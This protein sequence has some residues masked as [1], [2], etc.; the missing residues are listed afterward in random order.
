MPK[1][2]VRLE[3]SCRILS[4]RQSSAIGLF[5]QAK[6]DGG[7]QDCSIGREMLYLLAKFQNLLKLHFERASA[8][9]AKGVEH[10]EILDSLTSQPKPAATWA[11]AVTR[12][13]E[14]GQE[15]L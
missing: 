3:R 10:L 6:S 11:M 2:R 8:I 4:P 1:T 5:I 15:R 12:V 13:L 9:D 14:S 7:V